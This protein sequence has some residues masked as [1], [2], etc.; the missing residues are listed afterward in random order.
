MKLTCGKRIALELIGPPLLG[1]FVLGLVF[2]FPGMIQNANTDKPWELIPMALYSVLISVI[3]AFLIAGIPSLIYTC[4]MEW[5][6]GRGL[7]PRSG[8]SIALSALLGVA[9][10]L[11]ITLAYG[12][13]RADA[14][15]LGLTFCGTGLI[16]GLI[17]GLL[18]KHWSTEKKTVG[19]NLP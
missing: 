11:A 3:A 8:R 9:A 16:V 14:L 6:F 2:F 18:I 13:E 10:G 5:R 1:G 4:V 7:D 17:M 15:I 12:S 19:E